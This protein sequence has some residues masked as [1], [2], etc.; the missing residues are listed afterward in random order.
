[1]K[2][3]LMLVF[4]ALVMSPVL[5]AQEHEADRLRHAG[6]VLI[7]ILNIPY[8]IPKS[9]LDKSE[10]MIIIPSINKVAIGSGGNYGGAMT[11]RGGLNFTE[12]WGPPVMVALE[13]GNTGFQTQGQTTDFV[14][15]VVNSKVVDSILNGKVKLGGD[16]VAVAGPKG[17]DTRAADDVLMH[18]EILSYSRSRGLFA[19]VSLDG[20]TLRP[21]NS[22]SE[23]VYGRKITAREIVLERKVSTPVAGQLMVSALQKT[24]PT[25]SAK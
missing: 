22:A 12:P 19:G 25:R 6:E 20:F 13:S 8:N 2:K 1:M 3:L 21:D 11:C 16:A 4:W 18:T 10:C 5:Q 14:L 17:R 23:K 24:S 15:L 9:V 7:E